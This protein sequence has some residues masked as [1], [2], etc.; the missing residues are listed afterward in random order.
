VFITA[1]AVVGFAINSVAGPAA[2]I[3]AAATVAGLLHKVLD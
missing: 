1:A 2:A 3:T